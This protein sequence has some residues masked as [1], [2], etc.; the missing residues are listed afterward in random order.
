MVKALER[1]ERVRLEDFISVEVGG[2]KSEATRRGPVAGSGRL[3]I[4][5]A[6]Q[7]KA[8]FG[9]QFG[10]EGRDSIRGILLSASTSRAD[11]INLHFLIYPP[12]S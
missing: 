2:G 7:T 12:N 11:T 10:Q 5:E 6:Y 1:K 4:K 3:G 9:S 8:T